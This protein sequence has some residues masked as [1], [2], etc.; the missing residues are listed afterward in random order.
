MRRRFLFALTMTLAGCGGSTAGGGDSALTS[1]SEAATKVAS[2]ESIGN[3]CSANHWYGDG[4]CDTFCPD[5]D[6]D[7]VA[8]GEPVVCDSFLEVSDGKCGR[9]DS[10]PCRS[11]D[12]D[13]D[14]QG[15]PSN[16]G[17]TNPDPGKPGVAPDEPTYCA[18]ISE[19]P[20]GKCGRAADDPCRFQ[21]PDCTNTPGP[22]RDCDTSK[23]TCETFAP[24]TCPDGQVPTVVNRCYGECVPKEQCAPIACPAIALAPDGV[25][26]PPTSGP[27]SLVDPDCT[28]GG[29]GGSS[30]TG[31]S[32]GGGVAC[33]EYI[34]APD[35]VCSRKSDD[36]CIFQD[37][38]CT[39][40]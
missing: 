15:T 12:P 39:K 17:T 13:C 37:P 29:A 32:S 24:V 34:E 31:G 27:C 11:Q 40:R 19:V 33:A 22:A 8:A 26:S 35:G 18:A 5:E 25:C 28:S 6:T 14:G 9:A 38:D 2:G 3:A 20:N 10:D 23:V 30:G 21:D 16:P 4:A 1:K 7:C 36:P